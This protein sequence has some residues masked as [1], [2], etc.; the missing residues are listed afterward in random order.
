MVAPWECQLAYDTI[1]FILTVL[2]T[3]DSWRARK[4][5][6]SEAFSTT[7]FRDGQ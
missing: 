4:G 7:M 6:S 2:K 3:Y 5:K 1:V